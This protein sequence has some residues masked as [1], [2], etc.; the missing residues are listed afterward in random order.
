MTKEARPSCPEPKCGTPMH[1]AGFTWSGRNH[2]QRWR[3]SKCGKT[4]TKGG[5]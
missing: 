1:K 5:R 3:C 4:T 2:V